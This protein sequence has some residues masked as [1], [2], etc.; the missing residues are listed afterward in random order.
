[1]TDREH[2]DEEEEVHFPRNK[3]FSGKIPTVSD[4]NES[5]KQTLDKTK[6]MY[7]KNGDITKPF[8]EFLRGKNKK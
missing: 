4:F 6:D 3:L 7:F 2:D 8:K 5:Y 1:M